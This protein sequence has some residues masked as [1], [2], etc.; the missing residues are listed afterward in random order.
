[1]SAPV[2]SRTCALVAAMTWFNSYAVIASRA[3]DAALPDSAACVDARSTQLSTKSTR[4]TQRRA[5]VRRSR[6]QLAP[7]GGCRAAHSRRESHRQRGAVDIYGYTY[8]AAQGTGAAAVA[9]ARRMQYLC[10]FS[11]P[12]WDAFLLV[13]V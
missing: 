7:T 6:L 3:L 8:R 12:R 10:C 13:V 5:A 2:T 4:V 11:N 9:A 1:M